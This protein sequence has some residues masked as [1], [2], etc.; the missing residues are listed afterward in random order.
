[1]LGA[2]AGQQRRSPMS[3]LVRARSTIRSCRRRRSISTSWSTSTTS[4]RSRRRCCATCARRSSRAAGSCCSNTAR[5]I[6]PIPIRPEHKMSVAEAKMEVEAEGFTL[7]K[8]DEALPAPAHPDLHDND[9]E[10]SALAQPSEPLARPEP[11]A[12]HRA[13]VPLPVPAR[14]C[15]RSI[16]SRGSR[17]HAAYGNW[18][19]LV[20][21]VI[22][23][24]KGGGAFTWLMLGSIA[25]NYWMAIAV[26]RARTARPARAT[27]LLA[28]AVAVNLIVLGVF[29]YANFF[30]DNVNAL[31]PRRACR[32][33]RRAARAAADRHLVLH[34]SRD[35]VRRRRLPP[36]RDRAEEPGAR[37][38]LPAA[39]SAADRRPDHPLPRHRRSARAARRC[40]STTSPTACGAS[41]SASPRKC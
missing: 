33:D 13:D 36:R 2:A 34:L 8:V 17:E 20:A 38:A 26:D 29:K 21:S 1:M 16:S 6:R 22:F 30:A 41:S 3:T 25:F 27:A 11:V 19:L 10:L 31:L 9:R 37:G 28:F 4:C 39:L 14:F 12:V 24:A 5:K 35:L 40:R 7:S 15:W 18:L 32:A 23:Y